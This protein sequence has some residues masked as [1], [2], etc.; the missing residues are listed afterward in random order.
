M[1]L[2]PVFT[3]LL[4]M[5]GLYFWI[6]AK[7]QATV[8]EPVAALA[9]SDQQAE[10]APVKVVAFA[11]EAR[12]V[13]NAL[14]LRGRTEANR[15]GSA[16]AET[17]GLVVSDPLRAGARVSKGDLLC[18][19]DIGSR[20]AELAEKRARLAQA[21]VDSDASDRLAAKGYT[22]ETKA[23]A[24]RAALEAAEFSVRKVELDIERLDI[25][26]PFDGVLETDTAELGQLLQPGAVCATVIAL[27]PIKII[28]F[29]PETDVD[30]LHIGQLAGAR[31]I[32][33]QQVRGQI[34]FVARSADPTTR[35][36]KVEITA[37]NADESIRDGVTAEIVIPLAGERGHLAPQAALTLNDEGSLGVRIADGDVAR[38]VPVEILRD[39]ADGVWLK[40]LPER[41]NIIIVGHEYVSD[42][43][44][45]APTFTEWGPTR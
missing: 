11:S 15:K 36:F 31:L 28:G 32:S 24:Q 12:P 41:A 35:T 26:A 34:N 43:R 13:Q 7:P 10:I 2:F 38:F 33:G 18:Q 14:I 21:K 16:M 44:R 5:I 1:R 30:K 4:V 45:I 29:A 27:N 37:P 23:M 25:H 6:V 40:G 19:L 3:A 22:A 39:E 17:S 42:G 9:I 8:N 20:G